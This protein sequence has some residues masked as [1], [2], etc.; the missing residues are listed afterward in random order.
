MGVVTDLG[1]TVWSTALVVRETEFADSLRQRRSSHDRLT[2]LELSFDP[3]LQRT[4]AA[5]ITL[6]MAGEQIPP[7]AG[8]WISW[9]G[10]AHQAVRRIAAKCWRRVPVDVRQLFLDFDDTLPPASQSH[11]TGL[12]RDV[13]GIPALKFAGLDAPSVLSAMSL[14]YS[15][16]EASGSA[17]RARNAAEALLA[18]PSLMRTMTDIRAGLA[19][20]LQTPRPGEMLLQGFER[21]RRTVAQAYDDFPELATH[22]SALRAHNQYVTKIMWVL[23]GAAEQ[24][25]PATLTES[26]GPIAEC[27]AAGKRRLDMTVSNGLT[28]TLRPTHPV[29]LQLGTPLDGLYLVEKHTFAFAGKQE[30][31]LGLVAFEG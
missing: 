29:W 7:E 14:L 24:F 4:L 18:R 15:E 10:K 12:R 8:E 20:E 5:A 28:V 27:V 1:P 30:S 16:V 11:I 9:V 25:E 17:G 31:D 13:R 2:G 26:V 23:L 3:A 6:G 21:M 19:P 22:V